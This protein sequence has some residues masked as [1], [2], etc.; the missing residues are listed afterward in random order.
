MPKNVLRE[1]VATDDRKSR[2]LPTEKERVVAKRY[3]EARVDFIKG[4]SM[5]K[6]LTSIDSFLYVLLE[7]VI[8][9]RPIQKGI[10][11]YLSKLCIWSC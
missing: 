5:S 7:L 8:Q 9:L 6:R 4:F 1:S 10:N 2:H 11:Y 3:Y